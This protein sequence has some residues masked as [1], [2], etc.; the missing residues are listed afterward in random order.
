MAA[1]WPE[2]FVVG[3]M[4]AGTTAIA[5]ALA[6]HPRVFVCPVKEPNFFCADLYQW[7]LGEGAESG[8]RVLERVRQGEKRH[9]A[10][11]RDAASYMGLFEGKSACQIAV[12]CSTTYLY[13]TVAAGEIA[14]VKPD[15]KIIISLRD[16]VD[17]AFSEF[18]MNLGI[19]SAQW[20]FRSMLDLEEE[21]RLTGRVSPDH[22][23]VTAGMYSQQVERYI[24][25]FGKDSVLVLRF[26]DI[27]R[28]FGLVMARIW[29]FLGLE[30]VAVPPTAR[31]N[32]AVLP[33]L[34]GLNHMLQQSGAKEVI[35]RVFPS[36]LKERAKQLYYG[37][38][39][40]DVRIDPEDAR[41]LRERFAE[42]IM[43]L[44]DLLG[45]DFSDWRK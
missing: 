35:R 11:I 39:P 14:T 23:Y 8:A 43:R 24:D 7:G 27:Q 25:K 26:E 36:S 19:G 4:K 16:P 34:Q 9:H 31:R 15:A 13:S 42:D 18:L 21:V 45:E 20:P 38:P 30:A 37:R 22:R 3:A 33:R 10:Y 1:A 41:M 2:V 44:S 40:A 32:D 17:R 29:S 6:A 5:S 28:D 12:D